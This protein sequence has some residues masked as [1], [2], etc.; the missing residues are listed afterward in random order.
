MYISGFLSPSEAQSNSA[1]RWRKSL[2]RLRLG[3]LFLTRRGGGAVTAVLPEFVGWKK[4]WNTSAPWRIEST[5]FEHSVTISK[6]RIGGRSVKIC[7]T[8]CPVCEIRVGFL[9]LLPPPNTTNYRLIINDC[10]PEGFEHLYVW[11]STLDTGSFKFCRVFPIYHVTWEGFGSN[12]NSTCP[13][14]GEARKP[15]KQAACD[16]SELLECGGRMITISISTLEAML[17]FV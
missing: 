16:L 10:N 5:L 9:P 15:P 4:W 7:S 13:Q 11:T 6:S 2:Q 14:K 17:L 1:C 12:H 3:D 8:E